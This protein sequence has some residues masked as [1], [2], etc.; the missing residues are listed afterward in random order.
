MNSQKGAA[1]IVVLSMLTA[2]LMLGLTSMQSSMIDERLAGNY[3]AAA[4]AQ[5][6]AEN[7][8][9]EAVANSLSWGGGLPN[10]M[11]LK[12]LRKL[13]GQSIKVLGLKRIVT[14]FQYVVAIAAFISL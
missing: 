4:Q 3:K 9:A 6:R 11:T 14:I 8:A 12:L 2:S 13:G 5:M 1:L 7:A 10:L